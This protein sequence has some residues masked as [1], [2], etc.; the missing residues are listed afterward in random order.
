MQTA[1]TTS[2]PQ[3]QTSAAVP[4]ALRIPPG[5]PDFVTRKQAAELLRAAGFPVTF[6][7]IQASWHV[8]GT[9]IAGRSLM[10][11]TRALFDYAQQKNAPSRRWKPVWARNRWP[12]R[13]SRA[14]ALCRRRG[15]GP[16]R[17]RSGGRRVLNLDAGR[18]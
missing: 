17:A 6:R 14:G 9:Y 11:P 4:L 10:I 1:P 7:T 12:R 8:P 2:M 3:T 15:A 13:R 5:A 18:I 16:S